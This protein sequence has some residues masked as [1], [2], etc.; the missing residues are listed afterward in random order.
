M[1]L[2]D[3]TYG[4]LR[5]VSSSGSSDMGSGDVSHMELSALGYIQ[6][7]RPPIPVAQPAGSP[8]AR[9]RQFAVRLSPGL[10]HMFD[11]CDKGSCYLAASAYASVSA[12]SSSSLMLRVVFP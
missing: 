3:P 4:S 7:I 11:G 12:P 10:S 9:D 8:K 5:V 6:L 2:P 1:L